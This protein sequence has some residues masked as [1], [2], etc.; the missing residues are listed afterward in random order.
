MQIN[1]LVDFCNNFGRS[2]SVNNAIQYANTTLIITISK[3]NM[4]GI[5]ILPV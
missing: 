1:P 4:R 3:M 5:V 2:L